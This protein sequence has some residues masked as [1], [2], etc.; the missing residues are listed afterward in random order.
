MFNY[1]AP[2]KKQWEFFIIK[3]TFIRDQNMPKNQFKA[4]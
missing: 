2:T 1:K 4:C 3:Q